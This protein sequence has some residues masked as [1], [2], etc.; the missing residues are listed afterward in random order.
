MKSKVEFNKKISRR[1]AL[2]MMGLGIG[3]VVLESCGNKATDTP[4]PAQPTTVPPTAAPTAVPPTAAPKAVS[5]R[6][7]N[8]WTKETDAHYKGMQWLYKEFSAKIPQ[9]Y[10]R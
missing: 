7:Q 3:A 2:K 10:H 1:D 9:H 8:H 4:A 5:L 6:Y